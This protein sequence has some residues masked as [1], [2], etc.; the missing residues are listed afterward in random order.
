MCVCVVVVVEEEE[1]ER[2]LGYGYMSKLLGC[3]GSVLLA[4]VHG[5]K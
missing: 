3:G 2:R 4:G 5:G 1:D